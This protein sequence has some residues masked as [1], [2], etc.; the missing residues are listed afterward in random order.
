MRRLYLLLAIAGFALPY[1]FF[2][3]FPVTNGFDFQLLLGQLSANDISTFFA[4]DLIIAAIV[5]VVFVYRESLRL[6][7]R[8]WWLYVVATLLIGPSFAFPL[9]L[10]VR[11]GQLE[12]RNA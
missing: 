8:N 2:V 1:Y 9:F 3:S 4:V 12:T 5:L 10:F 11:L 7:I 6:Q